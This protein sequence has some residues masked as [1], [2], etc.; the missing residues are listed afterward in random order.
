[1]LWAV[2]TWWIPLIAIL[3]VWRYAYK[4]LPVR[5]DVQHWSMVFP[6]GMYAAGSHQFGIAAGLAPLL[7][8]SRYFLYLALA[9]WTVVFIGMIAALSRKLS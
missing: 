4:R 5:Y 7:I 6:L 2:T 9:A 1:M 8:I 3:N